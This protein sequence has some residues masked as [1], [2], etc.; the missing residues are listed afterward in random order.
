M[1][2]P[3]ILGTVNSI[4]ATA[5]GVIYIDGGDIFSC[6]SGGHGPY[7]STGGQ[8]LLNTKGTDL[9]AE[10]G[11]VNRVTENL[12]AT[13]RPSSDLGTMARNADG[14]MEGVYEEHDDDVTVI[15]TR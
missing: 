3:R 13:K 6:S 7:V 10:D 14:A 8:I 4:Y 5:N 2:N 15:V 11:T 12:T 1:I 9:V